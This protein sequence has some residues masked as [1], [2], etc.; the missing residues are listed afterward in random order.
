MDLKITFLLVVCAV[1]AHGFP[2]MY[3]VNENKVLEKDLIPVSSTVIPLPI[4]KVSSAGYNVKATKEEE[5]NQK[6]RGPVTLITANNK[7]RL[8]SPEK[9]AVVKSAPTE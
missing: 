3:K 4:Y 1:T 7:K 2:T 9:K 6:P 8:I 5:I